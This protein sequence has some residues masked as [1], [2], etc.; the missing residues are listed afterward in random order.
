MDFLFRDH[1]MLYEK[2]MHLYSMVFLI[3]FD[4]RQTKQDLS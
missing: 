4:L 1:F 3:C 2:R